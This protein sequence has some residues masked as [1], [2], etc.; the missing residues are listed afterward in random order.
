MRGENLVSQTFS[1]EPHVKV[2]Q[3]KVIHN[4]ND[5]FYIDFLKSY[6]V[7]TKDGQYLFGSTQPGRRPD[8]AFYM[9]PD[10]YRLGKKQQKFDH[11]AYISWMGKMMI[12]PPKNKMNIDCCNQEHLLHMNTC[13]LYLFQA[14]SLGYIGMI[15]WSYF[16]FSLKNTG[17]IHHGNVEVYH[18]IHVYPLRIMKTSFWHPIH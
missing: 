17:H 13:Y 3:D 2:T 16:E 6:Y 1:I 14:V 15:V 5:D 11:N 4:P 10:N 9:V 12:F 7:L 8:R 18:V